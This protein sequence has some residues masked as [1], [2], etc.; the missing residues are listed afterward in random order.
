MLMVDSTGAP[1]IVLRDTTGHTV[2]TAPEP[3]KR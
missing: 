2:W 1:Q 3:L